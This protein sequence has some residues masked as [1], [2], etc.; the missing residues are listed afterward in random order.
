MIAHYNETC[1]KPATLETACCET[2]DVTGR[3]Y[4][5]MQQ[6]SYDDLWT[7]VLAPTRPHVVKQPLYIADRVFEV[8]VRRRR[9][10]T[11]AKL[12]HVTY[13]IVSTICVLNARIPCPKGQVCMTSAA[14][15][16]PNQKA[17]SAVFLLQNRAW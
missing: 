4:I 6:Q 9:H 13:Q 10:E 8:S 1:S 5:C 14:S 3:E 2:L 17:Q 15:M 12:S 16:R 7:A 11:S